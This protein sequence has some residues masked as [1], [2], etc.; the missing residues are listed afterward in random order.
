MKKA[1]LKGAVLGIIFALALGIISMVMNQG[2]TDMTTEM[3]DPTY[4]VVSMFVNGYQVNKLH[5]YAESMNSAYL[6]DT[7]QPVEN[8]RKIGVQIDTYG[9]ELGGIAFEVRSLE[10][11]RLIESTEVTSYEQES[12]VITFEITLKDLVENDTEYLLVFLITPEGGSAIRYYTRIVMSDSLYMQEKLDYIVDFH[13]R[14][15]DKEEAAELT[16]YLESNSEGD[17]TTFDKVTIHSSFNQVTWGDLSVSKMTEPDITIKE[18]TEQTGSFRMEYLVSVKEGKN[19]SYYR[20]S[21]YY[22]VRYTPDRMYLLDYERQMRQI[23]DEEAD[24][25]V[26]DKIMLGITGDEVS[27]CESDGGNIFAFTVADK[28]YS[29]NVTDNKLARLFSFYENTEQLLDDRSAYNQ[30]DIQILNVDETGNVSFLVY[31]YM[32]RGRHEGSVGVAVYGYSSMTNTVEELTYI[33]YDKSYGLLKTDISKLSYLNKSGVYYFILDGSVY[34]VDLE[35][36]SCKTVVSG[37]REDGY[38]VS[39]SNEMLV[40]QEGD[41]PY[42]CGSLILMNLNTQKQTI[43]SAPAGEYISALGFMQEDLIYGLAKQRDVVE[44]NRGVTTFPMYCLKIQSDTGEVLKTY[45]KQDIYVVD[46]TIQD[47]QLNLSRVVWDEESESYI[48]TTDDQIMSTEEVKTGSNILSYV[49]TEL[50]ETICEIDVKEEID[51]DALKYLTPKEVLFEG[52]RSI[53]I[54]ETQQSIPYYYVYGKDGIEGVYENPGKAVEAAYQLSAVVVDDDGN[55]IWKKTTR[56]TRNQ[57][58]AITEEEVSETSG[59]LAVCLDTILKYEGVSRSTAR[60]LARGDTVLEILQADLQE[61]T[62]LDLS[63]CSLDA[64]LY[65]VNQDIPVL[66]TLADG[67]GVLIVGFNELNIVLMDPITGTLYKKGMNDSTEW[68]AENGNQFISYVRKE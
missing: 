47:N 2:N 63:G 8:D 50:Y 35:S 12:G 1:I 11:E 45:R 62:I 38:Q 26:N 32:N 21:E 16:K 34:A 54:P 5:G 30:H 4:P 23:F 6:R 64:V 60:L 29:Y 67:N 27:L 52:T 22:R 49:V 53:N 36:E 61:Y 28:L 9:R 55:Y 42:A 41:D 37:L 39:E 51:A 15:F 13:E 18:L 33:P 58:M 59:S 25:Y 3:S 19:V 56:S 66:A 43:I 14:T 57:I 46:S 65:Y 10:G 20:I 24:V 48:S 7:L 68:F 44:D 40:W 17:N 31:G